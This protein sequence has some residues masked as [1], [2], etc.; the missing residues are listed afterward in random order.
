VNRL[1]R[2]SPYSRRHEAARFRSG[3]EDLDH[4]FHRQ[5]AQD[6]RRRVAATFVLSAGAEV[7]GYYTLSA[8][9]V[10][11]DDLPA[12]LSAKLRPQP[13]LPA[14]ELHPGDGGERKGA[15]GES[16]PLIPATLLQRLAVSEQRRG[17]GLGGLLLADA[18][19]RSLE[20]SLRVAS[21]AVI[22]RADEVESQ[23]F[24]RAYGFERL[25]G[26]TGRLAL[27]MA[28][29]ASAR[30]APPRRHR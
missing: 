1:L 16:H 23:N 26:A 19:L 4:Y 30:P 25:R 24:Y 14:T 17:L 11:I 5:S 21:F 8:A 15:N 29:I 28:T 10:V 7:Y 22:V 18:L 6:Q 20:H 3:V 9:A 12:A 27:P 2:I 13:I